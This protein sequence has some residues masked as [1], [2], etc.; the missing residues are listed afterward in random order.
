MSWKS[1]AI[2]FIILFILETLLFGYMFKLGIDESNKDQKCAIN[3]CADYSSYIYDNNLC[4]CYE[5]GELKYQ[6][7]LI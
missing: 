1:I 5:N 6:E 3:V 7:V 4:Q 2:I